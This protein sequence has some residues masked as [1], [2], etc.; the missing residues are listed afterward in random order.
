[1]LL[2]VF[3]FYI[4]ACPG[5][6]TCIDLGKHNRH[7]FWEQRNVHPTIHQNCHCSS[8]LLVAANIASA[9]GGNQGVIAGTVTDQAGAVVQGAELTATH[10]ATGATFKTASKDDGFFE[11]PLLPLGLYDL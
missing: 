10:T 9:Q 1:M 3:P 7:H 11:F 4:L 6:K 5:F 2:D 8:V